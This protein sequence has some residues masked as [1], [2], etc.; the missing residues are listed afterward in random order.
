MDFDELHIQSYNIDINLNKEPLPNMGYR[1]P[2]DNRP[3]SPIFANL[4]L[5]GI[6]ES[7]NSGSLVDLVSI[8]SGYDFT[9]KV[10]PNGSCTGSTAAPINAGAIPIKRQDEA[11][12]YS[13][14]GAKLR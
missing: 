3:N 2:V 7:G 14:V 9:I 1:F 8:N 5:N 10:D 11:L 13:F 12:R 6:V 4:S